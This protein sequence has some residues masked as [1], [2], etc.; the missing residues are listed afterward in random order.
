M[1]QPSGRIWGY[2][3]SHILQNDAEAAAALYDSRSHGYR[4]SDGLSIAGRKD[5]GDY[6]WCNRPGSKRSADGKEQID[7]EDMFCL[8]N[9]M[10]HSIGGIMNYRKIYLPAFLAAVILTGCDSG[11]NPSEIDSATRI[12]LSKDIPVFASSGKTEAGEDSYKAI[13]T[14]VQGDKINDIG[15]DFSIEDPKGCADVV[16]RRSHIRQIW[17]M[18]IHSQPLMRKEARIG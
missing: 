18:N 6:E 17:E 5:A 1:A 16:R 3:I 7:D 15:W 8:G 9:V 13:V 10:P 2:K 14:I 12:S 11:I 4:R